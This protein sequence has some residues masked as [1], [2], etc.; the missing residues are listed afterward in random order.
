M[1]CISFSSSFLLD[2]SSEMKEKANHG[3]AHKSVLFHT[4]ELTSIKR[5]NEKKYKER[6]GSLIPKKENEREAISC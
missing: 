3:L 1:T 2:V 6:R 5:K 4:L